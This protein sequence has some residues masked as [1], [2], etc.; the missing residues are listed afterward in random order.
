ME[1]AIE[2]S[3]SESGMTRETADHEGKLRI[4]GMPVGL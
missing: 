2:A 3:L 1:L 4:P